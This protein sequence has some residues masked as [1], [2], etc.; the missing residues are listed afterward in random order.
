MLRVDVRALRDGAVATEASVGPDDVAFKGLD[1]H[2]EGPVEVTGA[3]QGAGPGT[4]RWVGRLRGA[5]KGE[6]ARCLAEVVTRFETPAEA[7][8]TTSPETADDPGVYLL[9]EPVAVIDLTDAVREEVALAT[10]GYPLCRP[11]CAGLC[12]R[13]GADLNLGPCGC[14]RS[15]S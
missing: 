3:M 14:A 2:L 8:Y 11:D 5:V 15:A 6:C 7:L 9:P 10:P 12:P 1:L 13:C 4:Y